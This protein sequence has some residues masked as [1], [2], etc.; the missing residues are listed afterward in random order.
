MISVKNLFCLYPFLPSFRETFRKRFPESQEKY[1]QKLTESIGVR[2]IASLSALISDFVSD[3]S[4]GTEN[5][6]LSVP[7]EQIG[8]FYILI[9]VVLSIIHNRRLTSAV[10]NLYAK[11]VQLQLVGKPFSHLI[12]ILSDLKINHSFYPDQKLIGYEFTPAGK[13]PLFA[14]F[15]VDCFDYLRN[16]TANN[17]FAYTCVSCGKI[18]LSRQE[19]TFQLRNFVRDYFFARS[20]NSSKIEGNYLKDIYRWIDLESLV[21]TIKTNHAEFLSKNNQLFLNQHYRVFPPCIRS[22]VSEIE[23]SG[24]TDHTKRL[25]LLHFLLKLNTPEDD[26]V[27]FYRPCSDFVEDES[28]AYIQFSVKKGYS[29]YSCKTIKAHGFCKAKEEND[30]LCLNGHF[31]K[32]KKKQYRVEFPSYYITLSYLIERSQKKP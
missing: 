26:V 8:D 22:I 3:A 21:K 16:F 32:S 17:L 4:E 20:T 7:P 10:S 23:E 2:G 5:A 13:V 12:Y 9:K 6:N 29:E 31:F 27:E 25:V 18:Y 1:F 15:S 28:R 14:D 24:H 11:F 19:L 30:D